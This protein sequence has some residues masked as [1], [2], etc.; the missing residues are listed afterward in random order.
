MIPTRKKDVKKCKY[1]KQKDTDNSNIKYCTYYAFKKDTPCNEEI[2]DK[3][4]S[5]HHL[6][7]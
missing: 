6:S 4:L 7:S 2:K 1:L 5:E 3:C